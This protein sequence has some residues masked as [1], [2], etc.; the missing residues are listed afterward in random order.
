MKVTIL[1]KDANLKPEMSAKVTFVEPMREAVPAAAERIVVVPVLAVVTRGGTSQ[2][3]TV[4]DG[5]VQSKTVTVGP[6]RQ[7]GVVIREGLEGTE[8]IVAQPPESLKTG[9][10]VK[11][12]A[13][14]A[15]L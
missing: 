14:P 3:F 9:D 1:D 4:V 13:A 6:K 7:D 2:V 5:T 11:V 8:T 10:R 15:G 12:T